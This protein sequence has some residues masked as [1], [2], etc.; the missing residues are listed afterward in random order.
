MAES[1]AYGVPVRSEV[2]NQ[3]EARKK[4]LKSSE[5][6]LDQ[7]MLLHNRGGWCKMVSSVDRKETPN[8]EEYT[9][10]LASNFILQGGTLKSSEDSTGKRKYSNRGGIDFQG[11]FLDDNVTSSYGYSENTGF[12]PMVGID[13]F[14]VISQGTMGTLRK[15]QVGFSVWSL[16]HLNAIEQLYFRPGFN[17]LVEYGAASYIDS[18]DDKLEVSTLQST[19]SED[20]IN[21]TKTLEELQKDIEQLEKDTSYNYTAFLARIINFSWSYNSEGG[22]DCTVTMQARGEVV[23][24]IMVFNADPKESQLSKII[25]PTNKDPQYA[26]YKAIKALKRTDILLEDNGKFEKTFLLGK[27]GEIDATNPPIQTVSNTFNVE[28]LEETN[29]SDT[30]FAAGTSY[31]NKFSFISLGTFLNLCNNLLI[32]ENEQGI[33]ETYLRTKRYKEKLSSPY[34]TFPGHVALDP[35]I[36]MLPKKEQP[37]QF[38]SDIEVYGRFSQAGTKYPNE[39]INDKLEWFNVYHILLNVKFLEDTVLGF[40][41]DAS[42]LADVNLF[43]C[44]K[45]VLDGVNNNLGSINKLD[46]DLDKVDNEWRV[47]DRLYYDPEKSGI[48]AL[49]VLDLMGLGS[50]VTNFTLE[51]KISGELS[52]NMAIAS[53]MTGEDQ[54]LESMS[55]YNDGVQDRYKKSLTVGEKE[56]KKLAASTDTATKLSKKIDAI[57]DIA[58]SVSEVYSLYSYTKKFDKEAISSAKANHTDYCEKTYKEYNRGL[59]QKGVK[60]PFKGIIP[61]NIDLTLDGISGLRIGEAFR[62][63]NNVLPA[64]YNDNIGFIITALDNTIES[65]NRWTTKITAKMFQLPASEKTSPTYA[66][67]ME[68]LIGQKE[69]RKKAAKQYVKTQA[70]RGQKNVKA[71][72]GEPGDRKNFSTLIVPDGFNLTYD[73]K[74]VRKINGV[75][76]KVSSQLRASFDGI[77]AEYGSARIKELKINVYSGTYNKRAKRGGTTWSMHSWGIAIDLYYAKNKLRTKAPEAAFSRPEYKKMIDIFEQNGWYSLGRAKNYDYMH[78][79][80]WNPNQKE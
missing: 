54:N 63:H 73:G 64:R 67:A 21:K 76:K 3:L 29:S 39:L 27:D 18:S 36:C 2:H 74:P 1:R 69:V 11:N 20:Y 56:E 19:I 77:L 75:H 47:V 16:D 28:G 7:T 65:T 26:F 40:I 13:S 78:F 66:A 10:K 51:T 71:M 24:S 62:I 37:T 46:L 59:R 30:S 5:R 41:G 72:Y 68:K 48:E 50:M 31:E 61:L 58:A 22:F 4:I 33:K 55:R 42:S 79:Q 52:S 53:A 80:A 23:E 8:S 25:P 43:T 70:T 12:R 45:K 17:V 38:L 34:I 60:T 44:I 14:N 57:V 49:S 32:P 15:A 35:S 6:S 9:S